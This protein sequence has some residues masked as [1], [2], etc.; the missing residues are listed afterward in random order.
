MSVQ[1]TEPADPTGRDRMSVRA[2]PPTWADLFREL[3]RWRE[4]QAMRGRSVP[5]HAVDKLGRTRQGA[6][7][8]WWPQ[9]KRILALVAMRDGIRCHYCGSP[10]SLEAAT[11]DH[12]F[13]R[14]RGGRTKLANLVLACL[15][16]NIRKGTRTP[17][18]WLGGEER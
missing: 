4:T 12:V 17:W 14:A 9:R 6:Y 13:P 18:E 2:M 1:A 16:C 5:L 11:I 10:L 15:S 3:C 8:P 7:P